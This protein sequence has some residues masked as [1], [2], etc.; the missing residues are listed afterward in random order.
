QDRDAI[1]GNVTEGMDVHGVGAHADS[2][3]RLLDPALCHPGPSGAGG[4]DGLRHE[5]PPERGGHLERGDLPWGEAAGGEVDERSLAGGGFVHPRVALGVHAPEHGVAAGGDPL[6]DG[7]LGRRR[8]RAHGSMSS[9][10]ASPDRGRYPL[11]RTHR[12]PEL[13]IGSPHNGHGSRP[14]ETTLSLRRTNCRARCGV[15][16]TRSASGASSESDSTTDSSVAEGSIASSST[17]TSSFS[18][19]QPRP[20]VPTWNS[21]STG[22]SSGSRSST[23]PVPGGTVTSA[24]AAISTRRSPIRSARIW[25][26]CFS[27]RTE[28]VR[29]SPTAW[30]KKTRSPGWPTVPTTNRSGSRNSCTSLLMP[31]L[32]S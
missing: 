9:A 11:R 5:V 28:T 24:F 3:G 7:E 1:V 13:S 31:V 25:A 12:W 10:S 29:P 14:A 6:H 16:K 27:Q 20:I 18:P 17:T 26:C 4:L 19:S 22:I 2:R 30:T 32:S 15:R 23:G 8:A 21:A